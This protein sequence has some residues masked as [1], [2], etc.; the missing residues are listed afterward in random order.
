[1][2]DDGTARA[3]KTVAASEGDSYLTV[4]EDIMGLKELYDPETEALLA[5]FREERNAAYRGDVVARDK[6]RELAVQIGKRSD[7]LQFMMGRELHQM[8][9]QLHKARSE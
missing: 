3:E 9:R 5:K 4:L 7:E 2:L 1:M 6:A 8:D